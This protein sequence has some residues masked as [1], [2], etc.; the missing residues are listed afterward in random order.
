[1]ARD[2]HALPRRQRPVE[3]AAHGFDAAPQRLDLAIARVGAR[4][5]FE[6]LDLLQQ[7]RDRLFEF[8]RFSHAEQMQTA[9]RANRTTGSRM[10]DS[11]LACRTMRA[12]RV[13][14]G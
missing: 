8:E 4:Q 10:S 2:E 6:R 11:W 13:S 3:V 5:R 9:E 12:L 7:H 14:R 1:M